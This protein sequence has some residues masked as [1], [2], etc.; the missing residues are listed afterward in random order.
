[1]QADSALL[2]GEFSVDSQVLRQKITV[3]YQTGVDINNLPTY[4]D[5]IHFRGRWEKNRMTI[6]NNEG[7]Y[8]NL[9]F[10]VWSNDKLS[11]YPYTPDQVFYDGAGSSVFYIGWLTEDRENAP[12]EARLGTS[13]QSNVIPDLS[14]KIKYYEV[15]G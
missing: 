11:S 9:S 3:Y 2:D 6:R 14:G 1:M 15:I 7:A 8:N 5:P 13:E 12:Q 4:S 10:T